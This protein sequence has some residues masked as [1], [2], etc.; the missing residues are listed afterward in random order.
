MA[1]L[2]NIFNLFFFCDNDDYDGAMPMR[3]SSFCLN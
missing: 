2:L 3:R 1:Q